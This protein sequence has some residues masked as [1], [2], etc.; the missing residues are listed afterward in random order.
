MTGDFGRVKK[1]NFDGETVDMEFF[2]SVGVITKTLPV[3][4]LKEELLVDMSLV[5]KLESIRKDLAKMLVSEVEKG[6]TLSVEYLLENYPNIV[7]CQISYSKQSSTALSVACQ[8]GNL[9]VV[10]LLLKSKANVDIKDE[11]ADKE[12]EEDEVE[13]TGYKPIHHAVLGYVVLL[14]NN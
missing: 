12:N 8:K 14:I 9:E 4:Q 10:K 3:N 7:D 13:E 2:S 5:E 11:M 1:V 6:A